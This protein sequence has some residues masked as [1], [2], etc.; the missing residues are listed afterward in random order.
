MPIIFTLLCT[1]FMKVFGRKSTIVICNVS[2]VLLETLFYYDY[3]DALGLIMVT[4]QIIAREGARIVFFTYVAEIISSSFRAFFMGFHQLVLILGTVINHNIFGGKWLMFLSSLLLA[5]CA[6]FIS[7]FVPESPFWLAATGKA[8]AA[9]QVFSWIRAGSLDAA[10]VAE[11]DLLLD[12]AREREEKG[13]LVKILSLT[14]VVC[15]SFALVLHLCRVHPCDVQQTV[16]YD[17]YFVEKVSDF[18]LDY[19]DALAYYDVYNVDK[20]R[21]PLEILGCLLH[22][23]ISIVVGRKI[24]YLSGFIAG[25]LLALPALLKI[26]QGEGLAR[27][28]RYCSMIETATLM[29]DTIAV[30]VSSEYIGASVK[31]GST[32][33]YRI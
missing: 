20:Y 23:V 4:W 1:I 29:I 7:I 25:T 13:V 2:F 9:E 22:L 21:E 10:D 16:M 30:E 28:A 31:T 26:K 33:W 5:C 6:L 27:I 32:K 19:D 18:G 14:F 3:G 17:F 8:E 11:F 15:C 12:A 24:I